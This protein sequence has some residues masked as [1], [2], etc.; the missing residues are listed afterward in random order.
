MPPL[1]GQSRK[2]RRARCEQLGGFAG[3]LGADG[4]AIDDERACA[5]PGRERA[6]DLQHVIV[7]GDADHH[8]IDVRGQR[9][10]RFGRLAAQLAGQ[11]CGLLAG[12]I[13]DRA[14]RPAR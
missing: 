12:A 2:S 14:S 1:T 5:Q 8:R 11:R 10:E 7:G 6:H 3:G 13:P 4:G 9:R